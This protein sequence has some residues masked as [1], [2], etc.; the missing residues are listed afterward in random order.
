[1]NVGVATINHSEVDLFVMSSDTLN[2]FSNET[3]ERYQSYGNRKI[4]K[5]VRVP[6]VPTNDIIKKYFDDCPN[7][8]SLDIEGM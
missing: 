7:F 5:V 6:L 3:G 1:M 4:E 2:N 8:V